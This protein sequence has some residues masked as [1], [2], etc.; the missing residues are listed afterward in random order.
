MKTL[1]Y[2]M[3]SSGASLF[4]YWLAQKNNCLSVIDLYYNQI[5]PQLD[6]DNVVVKCVVTKE[7][8][9]E[10]HIASFK[11]DNL[12]FFIRNPIENYLSLSEKIYASFGGSIEEKL[13]ILDSRLLQ[14]KY[15]FLVRYEDFILERVP[16][17]LGCASY[18][19]F[20][21]TLDEVKDYNFFH[22][23]WCKNNYKKKWGVGNIHASQNSLSILKKHRDY[24]NLSKIY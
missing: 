5:A 10:D 2:A 7:F 24:P 4:S 22:S 15:D 16:S 13:A 11:P 1:V 17:G 8:S 18:F 12:V 9:L 14:G 3:Q 6:H 20:K 23:S 21:R 19:D